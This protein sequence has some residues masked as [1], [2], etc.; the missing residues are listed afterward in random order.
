MNPADRSA[1]QPQFIVTFNRNLILFT[2]LALPLLCSLGVWQLNRAAEKRELHANYTQQQS[3]PPVTLTIHTIENL[4]DH[5]RVMVQGVFD[6]EHTWLL[7]NKQRQ[8]KVGYEIIS[9][10]IM[11]DGGQIL[12][13]RGWLPAGKT[14]KDIPEIKP[15]ND[16]VTIF[17]E[18]ASVTEHPLL[19]AETQDASWPR[20]IMAIDS[21]IMSQQLGKNLLSRY[22]KLDESSQGAFITDWQ[23]V[24][25]GSEKHMGYAFQ[26]FSMAIALIIWAIFANTNLYSYWRLKKNK[27]PSVKQ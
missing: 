11:S 24:N 21:K 4:N 7:D 10:F 6:N 8:G 20:I 23:L 5:Q 27:F 18:L 2:L 25:A 15:L 13:N 19:N 12:V 26:W 17:A 16:T 9:P 1:N 14:R 22:L 3:Q